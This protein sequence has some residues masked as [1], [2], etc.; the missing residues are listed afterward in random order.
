VDILAYMLWYNGLPIGAVPL[1]DEQGAL[2][3]M[4]FQT[5]LL[6]DR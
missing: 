2:E 6:T 3:E 1:D 5:P 4:T